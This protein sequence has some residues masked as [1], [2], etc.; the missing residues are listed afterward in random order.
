MHIYYNKYI[1]MAYYIHIYVYYKYIEAFK[2][3]KREPCCSAAVNLCHQQLILI[4]ECIKV[5]I[6]VWTIPCVSAL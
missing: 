3:G 1:N 4:L 6:W 2:Q 5:C